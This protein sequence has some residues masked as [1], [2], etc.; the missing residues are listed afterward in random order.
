MIRFVLL[1]VL[2]LALVLLALEVAKRLKGARIDWT[3]I[4]FAAGFVVLAIWLRHATG[5]G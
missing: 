4:G 5:L 3:G 2:L 1:L